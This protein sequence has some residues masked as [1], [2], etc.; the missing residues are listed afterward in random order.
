MPPIRTTPEAP[1]RSPIPP[2]S[3]HTAAPAS[4]P[5]SCRRVGPATSPTPERAEQ[6]GPPP[7]GPSSTSSAPELPLRAADRKL[8]RAVKQA[9]LGEGQRITPH[10]LRYNFGSLLIEAG[11]NIAQVSRMLGHSDVG[12]TLRIYV[13]PV[14]RAERAAR[15]QDSLRVFER[16]TRVE[17]RGGQ[18]RVSHPRLNAVDLAERSASEERRA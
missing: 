3:Q 18:R 6:E 13:H 4:D 2:S 5:V 1:T 16:G 15:S 7:G 14:E 12:T 10:V 11:E 8:D 17:Q 9:E